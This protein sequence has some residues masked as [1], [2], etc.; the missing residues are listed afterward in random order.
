MKA[1][2]EIKGF[3]MMPFSGGKSRPRTAQKSKVREGG[4]RGET[5]QERRKDGKNQQLIQRRGWWEI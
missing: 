4:R 5:A 2:S 3:Q 1:K